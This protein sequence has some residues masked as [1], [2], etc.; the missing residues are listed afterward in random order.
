VPWPRPP[1]GP[2]RPLVAGGEPVRAVDSGQGWV[3]L[4]GG[5][6]APERA[7]QARSASALLGMPYLVTGR[8]VCARVPAD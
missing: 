8:R 3:T 5:E 1:P 6:S 2:P 4:G 7:V